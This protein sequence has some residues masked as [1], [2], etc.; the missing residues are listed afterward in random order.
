M[1]NIY[2]RLQFNTWRSCTK[3][4][5]HSAS[6]PYYCSPAINYTSASQESTSY[7]TC[8]RLELTT[9]AQIIDRLRVIFFLL[10][11]LLL[12][13][14]SHFMLP[15]DRCNVAGWMR[16]RSPTVPFCTF[17]FGLIFLYLRNGLFFYVYDVITYV[18]NDAYIWKLS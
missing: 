1:N 17:L 9:T 15:I 6:R 4:W 11:L 10:L 2:S 5:H 7:G 18:Y 13:C 12:Y 14:V 16:A 3:V 8:V